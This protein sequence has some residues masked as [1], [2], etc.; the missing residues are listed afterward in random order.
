VDTPVLTIEPIGRLA[1][2]NGA[3]GSRGG[4]TALARWSG[5]PFFLRFWPLFGDC[6]AANDLHSRQ[7]R[8]GAQ[9]FYS[10]DP[11]TRYPFSPNKYATKI[12]HTSLNR[13]F[14]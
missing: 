4:N 10:V 6:V 9:P 1:N 14:T 7:T 8:E 11:N 5:K 2:S 13:N 12:Q 3:A